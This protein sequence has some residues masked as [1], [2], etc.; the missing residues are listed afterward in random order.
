LIKRHAKELHELKPVSL[1]QAF[2]LNWV[3]ETVK[4]GEGRWAAQNV[5][6]SKTFLLYM[7][8]GPKHLQNH[9]HVSILEDQ[10]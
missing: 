9:V 1:M 10:V 3:P 5:G 7:I 2:F 8:K 6:R 4:D